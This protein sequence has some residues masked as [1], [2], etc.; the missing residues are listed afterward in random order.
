MLAYSSVGCRV[1][2]KPKQ[3]SKPSA[4]PVAAARCAWLA[5]AQRGAEAGAASRP[6]AMRKCDGRQGTALQAA[7]EVTLSSPFS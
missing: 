2:G 6:E 3:R 4:S 5:Q 1:Q 7:L